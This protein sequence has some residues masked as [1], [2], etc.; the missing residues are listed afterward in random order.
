M[1][2]VGDLSNKGIELTLGANILRNKDFNWNSNLTLAHNKQVVEKLSNQFYQTDVVHTG[3][4]HDLTGMTGTFTQILKEGYPVGTFFGPRSEGVDEDGKFIL[5]NDGDS[6]VLGNA[7]PK[8]SLGFSTDL[9]YRSFDLSIAAYGLFGQK[10]LNAQS[11]N[12]SYPGRLP[13]YNV[14]DSWIGKNITEGPIYSSYWIEKGDFLRI[15]SI[16]FGYTL[17]VKNAWFDKIRLYVTGENLY[18][19][20]GYT[21]LDP[22]VNFGGLTNPGIDKSLGYGTNYYY[23]RPRTFSVGLNLVF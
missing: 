23:P 9:T 3:D 2:N 18:T 1:A 11:M 17:P 22:E 5:A 16:T 8:L 12:I 13:A 20:T 19:F 7:Q 6:E 14:L 10:I 4:L 21:G 15:Q